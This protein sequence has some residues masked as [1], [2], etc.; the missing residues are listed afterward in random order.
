MSEKKKRNPFKGIA[1]YFSAVRAELKKVVWPTFKQ[2]Q[3]N[4][5]IVIICLIL[6]GAMIW[7]IDLAFGLT[8]GNVLDM[9]KSDVQVQDGGADMDLSGMDLDGIDL[10]ALGLEGIDIEGL[11]T[12]GLEVEGLDVEDAEL[13]DAATL[14]EGAEADT[15]A[16]ADADSQTQENEQ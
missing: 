9:A 8:L 4:T 1:D 15:S 12:E 13:D 7:V 10:E 14:E 11:E 2:I 6:V 5:T 3:N 16:D